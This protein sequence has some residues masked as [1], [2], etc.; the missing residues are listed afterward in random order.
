MRLSMLTA[1]VASAI[2]IVIGAASAWLVL[3]LRTP[4]TPR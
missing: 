2:V 3:M 4:L 1:V